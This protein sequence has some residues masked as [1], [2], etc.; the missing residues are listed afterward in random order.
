MIVMILWNVIIAAGL[1]SWVV[2]AYRIWFR[3][4]DRTADDVV[5][6]LVPVDVERAESLLDP[7]AES[8]LRSELTRQEFRRRQR[9]RMHL[10]LVLVRKMA[11]NAAVLIEWANREAEATDGQT[12]QVAHEL[13]QAAAEV[14]LYSLAAMVKLRFWLLIRLD[15]WN[16]L[17][18][19]SLCELQEA[20]GVRAVES[21]ERL[22]TTASLLFLGTGNRNFEQL[23]HNL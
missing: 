1:I 6:F 4:P 12:L 8:T 3:F 9:K 16:I 15:S 14:R 7:R 21:Y 2:V 11:H 10:Y 20:A 13:Q 5:E 19:P 17:P 23:L 18:A 22:K